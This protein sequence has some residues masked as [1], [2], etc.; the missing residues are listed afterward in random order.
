M[1]RSFVAANLR[2]AGR[3][4]IYLFHRYKTITGGADHIPSAGAIVV[5]L[6][7]T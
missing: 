6:A 5:K 1:L 2:R 7:S 3:Q 4:N